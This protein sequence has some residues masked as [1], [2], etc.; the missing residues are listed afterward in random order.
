MDINTPVTYTRGD[1]V[2]IDAVVVGDP[3]L[4]IGWVRIK[5]EGQE[6]FRVPEKS[7]VAR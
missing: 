4:P 5:P 2:K 3:R 7:V 6:S 1:G